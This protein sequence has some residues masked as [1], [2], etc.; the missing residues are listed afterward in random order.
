M[1]CCFC[2]VKGVWVE[3]VFVGE[4]VCNVVGCIEIGVGG[5]VVRFVGFFC[6]GCDIMKVV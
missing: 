2:V 3:G 4:F 6:F 5:C 1:G